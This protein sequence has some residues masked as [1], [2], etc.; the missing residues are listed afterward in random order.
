M[1]LDPEIIGSLRLLVD[2]KSTDPE[3]VREELKTE[4]LVLNVA[5]KN[6]NKDWDFSAVIL[7]LIAEQG[8]LIAHVQ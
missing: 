2:D 3:D 1:D 8:P 4:L 5:L 7:P 6:L